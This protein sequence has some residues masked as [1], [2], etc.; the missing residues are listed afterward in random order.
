VNVGVEAPGEVVFR[1]TET[2]LE[3]RLAVVI[4][5]LPSA[6][7]SRMDTAN[8]LDPAI[9]SVLVENVGV[10]AFVVV[11]LINIETELEFWLATAISNF[12]SP[13]I[14]PSDIETGLVEVVKSVLAENVGVLAP[15]VVVFNNTETVELLLAT[16]ISNFPSPLKSPI[17]ERI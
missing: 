15:V 12:P 8:V 6:L 7:R 13:L 1:N 17:G 3:I 10:L 11:V 16:A 9:K 14:S 2:V 4:S 5:G